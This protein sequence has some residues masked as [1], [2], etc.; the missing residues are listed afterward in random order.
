MKELLLVLALCGDIMMGTT[1]PTMR[2]P[3]HDGAYI[4]S[5]VAALF[6][7]ADLAAGNLEGVICEGGTC[8]KNTDKAN[9]YAF[10]MPESYAHLLKDA[11]FDYLNLANNHTNDFGTYGLERT[12]QILDEQGI[13]YSGL[14]D[15]ESVVFETASATASARSGTIPTRSSIPTRPPSPAS[16]PSCGPAATS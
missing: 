2:L 15:C 10:R 12:R 3:E 9:N 11:G 5:D 13:H 8:S 6:Q 14:P 4:F 7:E 1:Y 16:S